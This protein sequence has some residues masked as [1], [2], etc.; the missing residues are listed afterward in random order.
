MGSSKKHKDKDREHKKKR[1]HRSR[2]RERSRERDSK[3]RHR[4]RDE[5]DDRDYQDYPE[6]GRFDREEGEIEDLYNRP[7]A[8]GM[9]YHTEF[10]LLFL[11]FPQGF[12][13]W[14]C[15]CKTETSLEIK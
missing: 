9:V 14:S 1:K 6:P 8:V 13:S 3:R 15:M 10:C 4:E 7:E 2:S 11:S 12:E 5:Y